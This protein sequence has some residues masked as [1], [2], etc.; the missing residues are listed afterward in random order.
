MTLETKNNARPLFD[1]EIIGRAAVDALRKLDPRN[2]VRNPVMFIVEVGAA[3]Y[4]APVCAGGAD[5]SRASSRRSG[6]ALSSP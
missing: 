2:Q 1:R 3:V 4:D 6:R 5:R